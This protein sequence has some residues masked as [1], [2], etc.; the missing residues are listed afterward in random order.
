[1]TDWREALNIHN[2][3][4]EVNTMSSKLEAAEARIRELEAEVKRLKAKAEFCEEIRASAD[5]GVWRESA[6]GVEWMRRYDANEKAA[7]SPKI[8]LCCGVRMW[9]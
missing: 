7:D 5:A 6:A 3:E 2:H 1:M 9:V 4:A 8:I